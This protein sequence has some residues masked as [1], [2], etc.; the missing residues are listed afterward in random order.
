MTPTPPVPGPVP[1]AGRARDAVRT[2]DGRALPAGPA[3]PAGDEAV[4]DCLVTHHPRLP[5]DRMGHRMNR[6]GRSV[7]LAAL[8]AVHG[9]D[10]TWRDLARDEHRRWSVP[11]LG[12]SV[13]VAHCAAHSAVAVARGPHVGV[14]LQDERDRPDALRWLGGLLGRDGPA[15]IRDFAE[16]EALIKASHLTKDAFARVRLPPWRPAWRP[17]DVPPYQVCSTLV[18]RGM[19]LALAAG[20]PADVRYWWRREGAEAAVRT[21]VPCL[22]APTREAA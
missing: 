19:H 16:C 6:S 2:P 11:A 17:T 22:D 21:G 5:R 7:I 1:G 8:R 9:L 3:R 20:A 12:L 15:S 10:V 4:I 14:D 13:S 18:G